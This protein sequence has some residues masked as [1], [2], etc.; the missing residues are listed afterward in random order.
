MALDHKLITR[1]LRAARAMRGLGRGHFAPAPPGTTR[2]EAANGSLPWRARFVFS[3][4]SRSFNAVAI[5]LTCLLLALAPR[6]N[7]ADE[8]WFLQVAYRLATGD[9]LYRDVF[10]GAT[11][12]SA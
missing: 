12:L 1:S 6:I 9:V 11:P 8:S 5:L 3:T 2:T 4:R 7:A 10:Y